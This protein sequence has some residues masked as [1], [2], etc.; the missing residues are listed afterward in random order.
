MSGSALEQLDDYLRGHMPDEQVEAYEDDL[1]ARALHAEA[2]ELGFRASLGNTLRVMSVRGTLD[3]WITE[4][5]IAGL[6]AKGLRVRRYDVD[7]EHF[8][9]PDLNGE[10][11]ILVTRVPFDL[12]G[13]RR[14]DAEV[15]SLSGHQLKRMPDITFDPAD[16]A[17]FACC[18]AELARA[19]SAMNTVTRVYAVDDS[20]KRLLC[21]LRSG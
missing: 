14:L 1:F 11:D 19:A 10:F 20:G 3:M 18:E 7:V 2:P 15:F 8:A 9:L 6:E 12:T 21:E 13:I 4:R 17:V 5:D 16:G